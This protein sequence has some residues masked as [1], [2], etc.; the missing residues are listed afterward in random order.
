MLDQQGRRY[1]A[2]LRPARGTS[3]GV[4]SRGFPVRSATGWLRVSRWHIHLPEHGHGDGRPDRN[5]LD[6]QDAQKG[7]AGRGDRGAG[8][9]GAKGRPDIASPKRRFSDNMSDNFK[10]YIAFTLGR[11]YFSI[12]VLRETNELVRYIRA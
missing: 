2:R 10:S 3:G 6:R 11:Q 5:E 4:V 9:V 7:T 8:N 1:P 12:D